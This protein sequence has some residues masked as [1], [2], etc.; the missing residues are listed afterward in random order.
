MKTLL[1]VIQNRA[2]LIDQ[3]RALVDGVDRDKKGAWSGEDKAQYDRMMKDVNDMTEDIGRRQQLAAVTTNLPQVLGDPIRPAGSAPSNAKP[4]RATDE[5]RT[6]F[7]SYL[8]GHLASLKPNEVMALQ[9]DNDELGGYLKMPMTMVNELIKDMDNMV[10]VRRYAR[11]F[12]VTS[13]D[14]LGAPSLD[15]DI[16]DADWT[17]EL[18]TG[19]EGDLD[20]GRRELKAH[21][22]AKR[23]KMSRKLIRVSALDPEALVRERLAYKFGITQEKG[24]FTGNGANQPLGVF[25]ASTQGISTGRDYSTGNTATQVKFDGLKGAKYTLKQAYW[26]GARW[27][28][29]REVMG[30]IAKEKDGNGQYLWMPTNSATEPDLLLSFPVDMSEYA[31]NTMT[32]G[33]YAGIL[34]NW[35][36][37]YW[38]I[39]SLN[40]EVQRLVELYAEQNQ[41]GFIGRYEGDGAPVNENAFVRVKLA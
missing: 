39:D 24:Y 30:Q 8:S 12:Q 2:Q 33:L 5:Y 4:P 36:A 28:F 15:G 41:I 20:L 17:T 18:A 11:I 9:A 40:M 19:N 6:A 21:P 13:S 10:F 37:G 26:P 32:T 38:I 35:R 14:S 25:V 31:P 22:M 34:G 27:T 16:A 7:K 1:E 23:V 3:A 29:H